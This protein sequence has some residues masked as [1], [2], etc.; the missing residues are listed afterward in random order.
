MLMAAAQEYPEEAGGDGAQ[1]EKEGEAVPG[2]TNK[3]KEGVVTLPSGLQYKI[4]K[5]GHGREADAGRH[6][7]VQLQG[8]A[9]QWDGV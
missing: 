3:T 9:D 8:H 5:A 1:A 7:G 2:A 4:L 6:G